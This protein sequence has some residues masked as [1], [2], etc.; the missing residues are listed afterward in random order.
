M[1]KKGFQ[2]DQV[3]NFRKEMEKM[4]KIDF[5]AAK[6]ELD[7]ANEQLARAESAMRRLS[8][9]LREKQI[10][11]ISAN[12]LQLYANFSRKKREQ[13]IDQRQEV[14]ALERKVVEKRETLLTAAKDKKVLEAFK[15]RKVQAMKRDAAERELHFL[16]EISIQKK[17]HGK[18]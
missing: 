7:G 1:T 4:R 15:E 14:V 18:R 3:L 2:L 5:A 8:E 9:E 16:D 12:D 13:I 17:G 11:G 10:D 6:Y